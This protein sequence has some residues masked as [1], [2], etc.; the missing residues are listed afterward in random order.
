MQCAEGADKGKICLLGNWQMGWNKASIVNLH[1]WFPR[2]RVHN[3]R[4]SVN[5]SRKNTGLYNEFMSQVRF[6]QKLSPVD[7]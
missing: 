5:I 7:S 4:E 1:L 3:D 6:E 2:R